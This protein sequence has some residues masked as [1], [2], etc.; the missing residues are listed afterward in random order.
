MTAPFVPHTDAEIAEM[1]AF[2]GLSSLDEL[3]ASVPEAI[4]LAGGLDLPDHWSEADLR[5]RL[6][7]LA[8]RNR[9][10]GRQLVCFAGAG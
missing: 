7:D 1:L 4:R 2:L 5:D 8:A 9:P 10:A 6:E 3:F